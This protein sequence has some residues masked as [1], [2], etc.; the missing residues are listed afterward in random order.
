M[1][2]L[3]QRPR[4]SVLHCFC[5]REIGNGNRGRRAINGSYMCNS[6][7]VMSARH[8]K[9]VLSQRYCDLEAFL[10]VNSDFTWILSCLHPAITEDL[11]RYPHA[12][13]MGLLLP[14]PVQDFDTERG[15]HSDVC[16]CCGRNLMTVKK[17]RYLEQ[18]TL[19]R[20]CYIRT[21]RSHKRANAQFTTIVA[22]VRQFPWFVPLLHPNIIKYIRGVES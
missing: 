18:N 22:L 1:S 21:V 17:R 12:E 19:C 5:G 10:E 4:N 2:G 9:R 13:P 11:M 6:H 15:E 7:G 16:A 3:C 20:T 8:V 14:Y